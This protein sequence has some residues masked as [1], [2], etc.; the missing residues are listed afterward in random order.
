MVTKE[1]VKQVIQS[2]PLVNNGGYG[3]PDRAC[4]T[5]GKSYLEQEQEELF[6][7]LDA[8]DFVKTTLEKY[9]KK[10]LGFTE[11]TSY[12]LKHVFERK[13]GAYISNGCFIVGAIL[14]G[15]KV[16][17]GFYNPHFNLSMKSIEKIEAL[18]KSEWERSKD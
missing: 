1:D 2:Y 7:N 15:Y 3:Y 8:I 5:Q 18:S 11:R 12:G 13:R 4:Y 14:A 16:S 10:T 6:N 9:G 17:H